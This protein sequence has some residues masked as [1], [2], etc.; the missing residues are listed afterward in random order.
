MFDRAIETYQSLT[1][2]IAPKNKIFR[3]NIKK[4]IESS[5][6][7][8]KMV[9]N[10][11][12]IRVVSLG[13]NINSGY[14]EHSPCVSADERFLVF[15]SRRKGVSEKKDLD[16]QYFEDIYSSY[17]TGKDWN[18]PKRISELST[19]G[20]D[21]S[22][23]LSADGRTML[24][25]R[26]DI[27]P[28]AEDAGDIYISFRKGDHWSKPEKL[29]GGI[30]TVYKESHA[31]FSSDGKT[32]YF[33]SNRPGGKGGMDIYSSTQNKQGE[34]QKPINL[35]DVINT[36]YDEI[37][38]FFHADGKT[39]FFS[40][41]GHKTIGGF[42]FFSTEKTKSGWTTPQNL[43]YPINSLLDD[44]YYT[45]TTDGKRAYFASTRQGGKGK[46]DLY[47]MK[48]KD[49]NAKKIFVI[50][51]TIGK[52]SGEEDY[53]DYRI[54]VRNKEGR[55][56]VYCPDP[57]N[58][59]YLY[60]ISADQDYDIEFARKGYQTLYTKISIPYAYYNDKNHGVINF[61][62]IELLTYEGGY[63]QPD[64]SINIDKL[65]FPPSGGMLP[66]VKDQKAI[67]IIKNLGI[68]RRKFERPPV[69]VLNNASVSSGLKKNTEPK[70]YYT[71]Q[72]KAMKKYLP[73]SYFKKLDFKVVHI[74]CGDGLNRYIIGEFSTPK[75]AGK[76]L[77][78]VRK[79]NVP[80][81]FIRK[82]KGDVPGSIVPMSLWR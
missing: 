72:V 20:H 65:G 34:W 41:K 50:R 18:V 47:L 27:D 48:L 17:F 69:Q 25:Y 78:K 21:A 75:Q 6:Y 67:L 61:N 11:V 58:G 53:E 73:L 64:L 55:E 29:K 15:T 74:K 66:V 1:D 4:L 12:N 70:V 54:I 23:S 14:V 13:D 44:I 80:D 24:L 40:S 62:R 19:M 43:G 5:E 39:L 59:E 22:V 42:D 57:T 10:P 7:A 30:N 36:E 79:N 38:P 16:G 76:V 33:T 26:A 77:R 60:I 63:T 46:L 68:K 81:A 52:A 37:G 71:I 2:D 49:L 8:R 28:K 9:E 35:G 31:A 82:M 56:G 32:I 3:K 45:P 51:G